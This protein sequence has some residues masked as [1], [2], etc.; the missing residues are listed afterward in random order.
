MAFI[1]EIH[2]R[3]SDVDVSDSSTHEFVEITLG[4]GEDPADFVLSFYGNDGALMD[5][6]G[7]NIQATGV[8]DGEVRLSSLVG[9]PDPENPDHTIYTV[10]STS[11]VRELINAGTSQVSDEANFIALTNTTTNQVDDAIG[12]G[13]NGPTVLSGG[14]AAGA[15]TTNAATVGGGQSVQFDSVGNNVSGPRTLGNSDVVCFC[16]GTRI[17]VPHGTCAVEEL[18]VG[19]WVETMDQGPQRIRWIGGRKLSKAQL[20]QNPKMYPIRISQ[21]SLGGGL[22]RRDLLVSRQH[23][24]LS[25]SR[26]TKRTIGRSTSL[27]SAIKLT[28]MAGIFV[29]TRV[30]EVEYFHILLDR[31]EVLLAEGAP[32][33]SLY[34]GRQALQALEPLARYEIG[35]LFP[36]LK[37]AGFECTSAAY[38]PSGREQKQLSLQHAAQDVPVLEARWMHQLHKASG[39]VDGMS[40]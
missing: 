24:M 37:E 13:R 11:A 40:R 28:E 39:A 20:E 16:A 25:S 23:R 32:S 29:D 6:V 5:D 17:A 3:T 22:P 35:L 14:A 18:R 4:P 34:L 27:V 10:T 31:H 12:I 1:S 7:D 33:E 19:D 36:E 9:V 2:Y 26:I 15:T 8:V 38:I 30:E 21:G